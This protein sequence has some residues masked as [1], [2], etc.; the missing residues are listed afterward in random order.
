MS[1]DATHI[2][3]VHGLWLNGAESLVLRRRMERD[4]G[5][6]VHPFRYP[7]VSSSMADI[8]ERLQGFARGLEAERL[9]FIGHSLGGLVIYR[10]LERYPDQPGG[11]AVFLGTPAV[12]SRA[13][14][15]AVARMAWAA[16][17]VGRCVAEELLTERSRRWGGGR[18]LGIIA[19]TKG[20]GIG[21]FFAQF[22]EE[23]DGTVSVSETRLPGVT[24]HVTLPVSHMGML[25]SA[26]VARETCTFLETG[27][28][29]LNG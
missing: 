27:R 20:R 23:S 16:T 14:V 26:R 22:D 10:F 13:A 8:T 7:S 28:F 9:H 6:P 1:G 3:Y 24:D 29:S 2:I 5:A 11:R 15:S 12:E 21:Q 4:F 17:L 19:G 18:D 25:L